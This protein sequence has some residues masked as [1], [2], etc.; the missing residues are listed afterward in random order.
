MK[1]DYIIKKCSGYYEANFRFSQSRLKN[2]CTKVI[3][4]N[5]VMF[6][7]TNLFQSCSCGTA[8]RVKIKCS[9]EV[10]AIEQIG[11]F[12]RF[13]FAWVFKIVLLYNNKLSLNVRDPLCCA[14]VTDLLATAAVYLLLKQFYA[15]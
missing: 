11:L 13:Q 10:K 4:A 3:P 2:F 12:Y 9:S 7:T 8:K 14:S 5:L 1:Y 15:K 6:N